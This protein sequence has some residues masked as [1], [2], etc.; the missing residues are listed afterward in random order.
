MS[1]MFKIYKVSKMSKAKG[2]NYIQVTSEKTGIM[3]ICTF[4]NRY[5]KIISYY[6]FTLY[7]N[8]NWIYLL[9]MA[10]RNY[11]LSYTKLLSIFN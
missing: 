5:L 8:F 3:K 2:I 4:C 9:P 11:V 7:Q 6:V 1:K 10:H